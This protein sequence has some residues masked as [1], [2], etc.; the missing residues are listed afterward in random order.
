M[1][2]INSVKRESCLEMHIELTNQIFAWGI[3][4]HFKYNGIEQKRSLDNKE[5]NFFIALHLI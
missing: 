2:A 3:V 5:L 4:S 1:A